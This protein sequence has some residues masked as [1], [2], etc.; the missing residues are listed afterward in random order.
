MQIRSLAS[1]AEPI[2]LTPVEERLVGPNQQDRWSQ[3]DYGGVTPAT[4]AGV[5]TQAKL[6]FVEQWADLSGFM[7]R[8]DPHLR[9]IYYTRRIA[10]ASIPWRV[11]P[12]ADEPG[13]DDELAAKLCSEALGRI[14]DLER[15]LLNALDGIGRGY[16]IHE[17]MWRYETGVWWPAELSWIHARRFR[18]DND[19]R[20]RLWDSGAAFGDDGQGT[21]LT[22]N[23]FVI[24]IPR[25]ISEYPT[26]TG[27]LMSVAWPWMFKRWDVKFWL[28]GSE[29]FANPLLIGVVPKNTP[30]NVK[31][32][33]VTALKNITADGAGVIEEGATVD[34][35]Q[36]GTASKDIWSALIDFFNAEMTKGLLGSTDNVEASGGSY[37]RAESQAATSI[38]PRTQMDARALSGTIERDI[39]R[40]LIEFNAHLFSGGKMPP[41]PRLIFEPDETTDA[42]LDPAL[43]VGRIVSRNEVRERNGLPPLTPEQGGEEMLDLQPTSSGFGG[44]TYEQAIAP[45]APEVAPS[46]L[47]VKPMH[48]AASKPA[49]AP[50][51]RSL[52]RT[53]SRSLMMGLEAALK[54]E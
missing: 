20:L 28:N 35:K 33:L 46:P 40:P 39:F 44:G 23:K 34:V 49:K 19:W 43:F 51:K 30:R 38:A 16:S 45:A 53:S 36:L 1:N 32:A 8:T 50:G 26:L 31:V 2:E 21:L 7:V 12:G 27:E 24:H 47:G 37:A 11:E 13:N 6:G 41:I 5:L 25:T 48:S 29:R 9:G 10:V 14:H 54:R 3:Q 42:P 15:F 22:P 17:I 4:L 18:F 52:A